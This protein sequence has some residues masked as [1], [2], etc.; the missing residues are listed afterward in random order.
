METDRAFWRC[1]ELAQDMGLADTIKKSS[2]EEIVPSLQKTGN[3][4]KWLEEAV[5]IVKEYGLRH[6]GGCLNIAAVSWPEDLTYPISFILGLMER[7]EKGEQLV[8]SKELVD[9][10]EEAVRKF[11][12][13]IGTDEGK[14]K[15]NETLA[16]MQRLYPWIEDHNFLLEGK[17]NTLVHLKMVELGRR[18]L[19]EEYIDESYDIFYLTSNELRLLLHDLMMKHVEYRA[20]HMEVRSIV[21]NRKQIR[22]KQLQ[23]DFPIV[24]GVMPLEATKDPISMLIYGANEEN[25]ER[26]SKKWEHPEEIKE[27]DGLPAAP[28]VTEGVARVIHEVAQL[29]EI[30]QDEILVCPATNPMWNP[31]CG[32]IKGLVCDLGGT[33]CHAGI[34][35][36]EYG[37][38]A[39]VGTGYATKILRTGDKIRVDGSGGLV[40]R[41]SD[42]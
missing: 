30:Q 4:R 7:K 16:L 32:K 39:V 3:G 5:N 26:A 17:L 21:N 42:A 24:L 25:I 11:R 10:R 28:G 15:F 36:R 23:G 13:R 19:N 8:P 31:V 2:L 40:T 20:N 35:A 34:I 14:A 18:L 38:P 37:I 27:F 9:G 22:E 1:G 29:K 6:T 41:L 33:L 12:E